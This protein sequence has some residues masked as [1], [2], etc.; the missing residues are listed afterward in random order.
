MMENT[1][2]QLTFEKINNIKEEVNIEDLVLPSKPTV[3]LDMETIDIKEEPLEKSSD[4]VSIHES[5]TNILNMETIDIKEEPLH[6]VS[7]D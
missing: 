7:F 5:K 4:T 3:L 2:Q 6:T 1:E